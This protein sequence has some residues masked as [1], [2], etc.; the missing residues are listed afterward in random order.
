VWLGLR[1]AD[2]VEAGALA[3]HGRLVDWLGQSG[4]AVVGPDRIR[5]TLRGFLY[6]DQVARRVLEEFRYS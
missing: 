5:P 4:L 1:T 3:G 2:G 6:S